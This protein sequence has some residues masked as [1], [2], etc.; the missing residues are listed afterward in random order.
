M[1]SLLFLILVIVLAVV[2]CKALVR[3]AIKLKAFQGA[4]FW[5]SGGLLAGIFVL[6]GFLWGFLAQPEKEQPV[7]TTSI[8]LDQ[9][10][11][12]DDVPTC[13]LPKRN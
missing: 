5:L 1:L 8:I 3:R 12:M 6:I 7:A 13:K 9:S 10:G 11:S 2:A 4:A